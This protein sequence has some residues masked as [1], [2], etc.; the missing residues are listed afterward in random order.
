MTRPR[1]MI[2][3]H[4]MAGRAAPTDRNGAET[5]SG[6]KV[7]GAA[8][9]VLCRVRVDWLWSS[10]VSEVEPSGRYRRVDESVIAA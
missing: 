6:I 9:A 8:A 2:G 3:A 10:W 5:V 4:Q 7:G 1:S